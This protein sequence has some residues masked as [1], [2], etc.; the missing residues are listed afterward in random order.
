[1]RLE[2][3]SRDARLTRLSLLTRQ[4]RIAIQTARQTLTPLR[5]VAKQKLGVQSF[6]TRHDMMGAMWR[7]SLICYP[8]VYP[9]A[10]AT[11][12]AYFFSRH[13]SAQCPPE[14]NLHSSK[15]VHE[16]LRGGIL[17]ALGVAVAM[18]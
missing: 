3:V 10:A 6:S 16:S 8:S 2:P 5:Y 17:V 7:N 1:M 15:A 11:T 12:V 9:I 14:A 13:M 4:R 18:V